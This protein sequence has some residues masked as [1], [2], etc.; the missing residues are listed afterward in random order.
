MYYV[1]SILVLTIHYFCRTNWVV[2]QRSWHYT[3]DI[4][5][6]KFQNDMPVFGEIAD[7]VLHANGK[8]LLVTDFGD[9][10]FC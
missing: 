6:I 1:L 3:G 10:C 4:V 5:I 7:I 9:Y 8:P 2:I